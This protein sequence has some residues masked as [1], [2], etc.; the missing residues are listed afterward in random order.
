MYYYGQLPASSLFY[1]QYCSDWSHFRYF[2]KLKKSWSDSRLVLV[3]AA[4]ISIKLFLLVLWIS[5]DNNVIDTP[6]FQQESEPPYYW[7]KQPCYS[8]Y[9]GLWGVAVYMYTILLLV[10]LFIL[11]IKTRK[12][13]HHDFK[14][15]K[16]LSTL[17]LCILVILL[18]FGLLWGILRQTGYPIASIVCLDLGYSIGV[19]VVQTFLFLP[20][21][22]PPMYRKFKK[23]RKSESCG[24]NLHQF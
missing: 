9:Q 18:M 23:A 20:E 5:V 10:L 13:S 1:K 14:D 8:D 15:T 19:F 12:V 2:G 21:V 16:K 22:V 6:E 24:T 3:I 7:V 17:V 11:A 4:I